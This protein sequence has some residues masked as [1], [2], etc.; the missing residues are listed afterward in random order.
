MYCPMIIC[1]LPKD[2]TEEEKKRD[3]VKSEVRR[4]WKYDLSKACWEAD[5]EAFRKLSQLDWYPDYIFEQDP[6]TSPNADI[7]SL[8]DIC[9]RIEGEGR[10]LPELLKPPWNVPRSQFIRAGRVSACKADNWRQMEILIDCDDIPFT[11]ED[12]LNLFRII[13]SSHLTAKLCML[14]YIDRKTIEYAYS[15]ELNGAIDDLNLR[16]DLRTC[17]I[18][19][20]E[21]EEMLLPIEDIPENPQIN[22]LLEYMAGDWE[23]RRQFALDRRDLALLLVSDR[24]NSPLGMLP[25]HLMVNIIKFTMLAGGIYLCKDPIL[26]IYP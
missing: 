25:I 26:R 20:G 8:F 11:P 24:K 18:V 7:I 13:W 23:P 15:T 6:N 16:D 9:F 10:L 1:Y 5:V 14:A 19:D 4:K 21:G 12:R 3:E 17:E 2:V 22:E